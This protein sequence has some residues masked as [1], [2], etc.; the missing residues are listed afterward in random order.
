M[1]PEGMLYE[2]FC[3][4]CAE[5]IIH[6][7]HDE[8]GEAEREVIAIWGRYVARGKPP[9]GNPRGHVAKAVACST[10]FTHMS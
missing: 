2:G 7:Y 4:A 3:V 5:K 6:R 9:Y 1:A 8:F 10:K